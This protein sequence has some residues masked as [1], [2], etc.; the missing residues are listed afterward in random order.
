MSTLSTSTRENA[1]IVRTRFDL[2]YYFLFLT[3]YWF[4]FSRGRRF[5]WLGR[6]S[7]IGSQ[8]TLPANASVANVLKDPPS[9][10]PPTPP[11]VQR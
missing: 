1:S 5:P 8:M 2:F 10:K 9:T 4:L 11:T 6:A 7:G 3:D